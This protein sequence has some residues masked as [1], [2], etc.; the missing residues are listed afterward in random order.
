MHRTILPLSRQSFPLHP[1]PGIAHGVFDGRHRSPACPALAVSASRKPANSPSCGT[2]HGSCVHGCAPAA[3]SLSSSIHTSS[4][5]EPVATT[6]AWRSPEV[7]VWPDGLM[8]SYAPLIPAAS[9]TGQRLR[10]RG[11]R[12]TAT[13]WSALREQRHVRPPRYAA[14]TTATARCPR[15]GRGSTLPSRVTRPGRIPGQRVRP[16]VW[17]TRNRCSHRRSQMRPP[18]A[19]SRLRASPIGRRIHWRCMRTGRR[20]RV[21]RAHFPRSLGGYPTRCRRQDPN[22]RSPSASTIAR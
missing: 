21:R 5:S 2:Q 7:V 12:R 20:D 3:A 6:H 14:A 9:R 22:R 19:R 16:R 8:T 4:A 17:R 18:L 10:C 1:L 11:H 13:V 15:A